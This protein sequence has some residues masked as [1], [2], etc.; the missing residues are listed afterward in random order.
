MTAGQWI[1]VAMIAAA[2]Y[3]WSAKRVAAFV[4]RFLARVGSRYPNDTRSIAAQQE[5]TRGF[6]R[7][8]QGAN[9]E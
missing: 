3:F 5:V 7:A 1:G 4:G 2:A 8:T 6:C 9:H